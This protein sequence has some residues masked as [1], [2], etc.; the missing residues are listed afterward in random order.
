M[1]FVKLYLVPSLAPGK[2][3]YPWEFCC[4]GKL[5]SF[6]WVSLYVIWLSMLSY[7][8]ASNQ[9]QNLNSSQTSADSFKIANVGFTSMQCIQ[10]LFKLRI[11]VKFLFVLQF[12][13]VFSLLDVPQIQF[14]IIF[15]SLSAFCLLEYS[16]ESH[17]T[18]FEFHYSEINKGCQD[19]QLTQ[20]QKYYGNFILPVLWLLTEYPETRR[21]FFSVSS[22]IPVVLWIFQLCW[23]SFVFLISVFQLPSNISWKHRPLPQFPNVVYCLWSILSSLRFKN[24]CTIT[25]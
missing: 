15:W 3:S 8:T 20:H 4:D 1:A 14:K 16:I 22:T 25:N 11:C 18:W 23:V 12:P 7:S 9:L 24:V 13:P 2:L 19:A 6:W 21:G 17:D 5:C 10:H